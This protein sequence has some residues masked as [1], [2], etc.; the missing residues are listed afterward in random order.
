MPANLLSIGLDAGS[1]TLIEEWA[2]SGRLPN[3]ARLISRASAHRLE[4]PLES[5]PGGIWP[6][7][8]TGQLSARSGVYYHPAQLRSGEASIRRLGPDEVASEDLYWAVASDAG[9]RVC[10]MDIPQVVR[11]HDLN[12]LQV[13][14]WGLHDRTFGTSSEPPELIEEIHARFGRYPAGNCDE[15]N[16]GSD[17]ACR[18]LLDDL[19]LGVRRRTEILLDL[20]GRE[21]WDLFVCAYG[22]THCA[23]HQLWRYHDPT[24]PMHRDAGPELREGLFRIYREIDEGVG[25]LV[26]AAGPDARIALVASHGMTVKIGGPQLLPEVLA[27]LGC[28]SGRNG[29]PARALRSL[30]NRHDRSVRALRA[31]ARALAG[32]RGTRAAQERVGGLRQP[33][34]SPDTLAACLPNNRCGA[35]RFNLAGREP[36]GQVKPGREVADLAATITEALMELENPETGAKIVDRV[37]PARQAFGDDHHPD[38]PDLVV[39]FRTDSGP[40]TACRSPRI[41][42]VRLPS[43]KPSLPRTGDHEPDSRV[44][45]SGRG[46]MPSSGVGVGRVV[47][48]PATILDLLGVRL[49]AAYDGRPLPLRYAAEPGATVAATVSAR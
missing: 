3:F 45:F 49:P 35:I 1:A 41:G 5:L 18:R 29:Y 12:G 16:D 34:E 14:E 42:T 23:G 17:A 11:V 43:Y 13:I 15:T 28:A 21:R 38:L 46:I 32:R 4:C 48:V 19:T 22:E 36:F 26:D 8:T 24:H 40:L 6:E 37:V 27:R 25:R 20:L 10:V 2:A 47:D 9:Y 44:W 7:L 39:V 31:V 30:Q 33:F